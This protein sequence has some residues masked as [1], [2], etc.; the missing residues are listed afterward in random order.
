MTGFL[1][2]PSPSPKD[3]KDKRKAKL[4]LSWVIGYGYVMGTSWVNLCWL[5]KI[6]RNQIKR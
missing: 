3:T 1:K 6:D 4:N 2:Q 5:K